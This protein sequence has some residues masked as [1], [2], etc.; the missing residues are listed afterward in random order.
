MKRNLRYGILF[1]K[2]GTNFKLFRGSLLGK[3][4]AYVSKSRTF[5]TEVDQHI[6]N[7]FLVGAEAGATHGDH[8]R[9]S[10]MATSKF[11]ILFQLQS[12]KS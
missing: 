11:L 2:N 5:D 9:E 3:N 4:S 1:M 6:L 10:N 8:I 12:Q 7:L